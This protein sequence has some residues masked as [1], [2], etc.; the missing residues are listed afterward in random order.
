MWDFKVGCD[1]SEGQEILLTLGQKTK[2]LELGHWNSASWKGPWNH[3]SVSIEADISQYICSWYSNWWHGWYSPH[4]PWT[5]VLNP[6]V[7]YAHVCMPMYAHLHQRCWDRE[8]R[9]NRKQTVWGGEGWRWMILAEK[10]D[11]REKSVRNR[12]GR[13]NWSGEWESSV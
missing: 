2:R 5:M 10:G 6:Y 9:Q 3:A 7:L 11:W 12:E 4:P 8:K 1:C 13:V